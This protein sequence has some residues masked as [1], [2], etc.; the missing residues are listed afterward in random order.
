MNVPCPSCTNVGATVIAGWTSPSPSVGDESPLTLIDGG[1]LPRLAD[2]VSCHAC[3]FDGPPR[4]DTESCVAFVHALERDGGRL[5]RQREY[6]PAIVRFI[7][8]LAVVPGYTPSIAAIASV[9]ID[10][11]EACEP[12][13]AALRTESLKKADALLWMAFGAVPLLPCI[14]LLLGRLD[15]AQGRAESA[16]RWYQRY[17]ECVSPALH[18][19]TEE[20]RFLLYD[21]PQLYRPRLRPCGDG[22]RWSPW[23]EAPK[24]TPDRQA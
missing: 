3:G 21:V 14:H 8:T 7:R 20:A 1:L 4:F 17:I 5:A 24:G 19:P 2:W 22:W 6:G 9:L 10:A 15:A 16:R 23:R 18:G 12:D 13:D 11:A